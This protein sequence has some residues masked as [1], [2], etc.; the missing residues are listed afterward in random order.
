[1]QERSIAHSAHGRISRCITAGVLAHRLTQPPQ[2]ENVDG[3]RRLAGGV[4]TDAGQEQGARGGGEEA[5]SEHD[6]PQRQR[7]V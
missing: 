6:E 4:H 5:G 7:L 3:V 1:M 2:T